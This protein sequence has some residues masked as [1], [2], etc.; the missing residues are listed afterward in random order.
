MSWPY[1]QPM[2]DFFGFLAR[3]F[4]ICAACLFGFGLLSDFMPRQST[5]WTRY[6]KK[7]DEWRSEWTRRIRGMAQSMAT[8]WLFAL[9]CL[10]VLV[11]GAWRNRPSVVIQHNVA[12][13]RQL[14]NGDWVMRSDEDP[15]LV[16]RTCPEDSQGGVDVNG[17]LQ[18][19]VGYV[20]DYA[21]WEERGTCKSILRSDLGFWFRD[22]H[23]N[24]TYRK[25]EQEK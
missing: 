9:A 14:D 13:Y 23:N 20:A 19:A 18:Q 24:F 1:S 17:L 21:K 3:F 22:E 7:W 6:E 11:I 12:I 16:W 10:G 25:I 5:R 8:V 15:S 2:T 4:F